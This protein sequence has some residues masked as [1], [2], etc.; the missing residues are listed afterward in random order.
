VLLFSLNW[1]GFGL[2]PE[3]WTIIVLLV[4]TAIEA[5]VS[6]RRGDVAYQLVIIW[7]FI[8]IAVRN[9]AA[10]LVGTTALILAAVVVIIGIVGYLRHRSITPPQS[11]I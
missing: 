6:F 3:I 1:N 4:A 9:G 8:G 7:A 10:S 5:V 11:T 2:A